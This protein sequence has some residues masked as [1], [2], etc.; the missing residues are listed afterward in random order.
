VGNVMTTAELSIGAGADRVGYDHVNGTVLQS[1][2]AAPRTDHRSAAHQIRPSQER[3]MPYVWQA[4]PRGR[5][6]NNRQRRR[7]YGD[8]FPQS[9]VV[10]DGGDLD[11]D[12]GGD[13]WGGDDMNSVGTVRRN[14]N[15][16]LVGMNGDEF[17]GQLYDGRGNRVSLSIQTPNDMLPPVVDGVETRS[18][19]RIRTRQRY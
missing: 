3:M 2:D 12:S 4:A 5:G 15:A 14:G 10:G 16:R 7:N 17:T 18:G 13:P 8:D 11:M 1:T 9:R 19:G 6:R